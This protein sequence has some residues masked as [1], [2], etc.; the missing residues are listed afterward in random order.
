[1]DNH[2]HSSRLGG[3]HLPERHPVERR[4][5]F[6]EVHHTERNTFRPFVPGGPPGSVYSKPNFMPKAEM[7]S[8]SDMKL[9]YTGES[10]PW[11]VMM[12]EDLRK[13]G[14]K[15]GPPRYEGRHYK[16]IR[17]DRPIGR[18]MLDRRGDAMNKPGNIRMPSPRTHL[19]Y[20]NPIRKSNIN[21]PWKWSFESICNITVRF[22]FCIVLLMILCF[23][24]HMLHSLYLRSFVEL[25]VQ[26]RNLNINY[27]G[28]YF[29]I[30]RW[31][32]CYITCLIY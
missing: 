7:Q 22:W 27:F 18:L 17:H 15:R 5:S 24:S 25:K 11:P 12:R 26:C 16:E 28:F 31:Q 3:A 8:R 19:S 9:G 29:I 30:A 2:A 13:S 32:Y 14:E 21:S 23:T 6:D 10:K 4:H 1:M 20:G